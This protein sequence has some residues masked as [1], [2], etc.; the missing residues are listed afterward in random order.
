MY[1]PLKDG[2]IVKV[3]SAAVDQGLLL[4]LLVDVRECVMDWGQTPVLM[5]CGQGIADEKSKS[6]WTDFGLGRDE[7]EAGS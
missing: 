7:E 4:S 2:R 5:C 1:R 3:N 6:F